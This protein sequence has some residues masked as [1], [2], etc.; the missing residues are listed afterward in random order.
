MGTQLADN[1]TGSGCATSTPLRLRLSRTPKAHNWL[2]ASRATV[3]D[4]SVAL[5]DLIARH[6]Q[7]PL[8]QPRRENLRVDLLGDGGNKVHGKRFQRH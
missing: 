7:L 2:I 4:T 3:R 8:L 5:R 1:F 6:E